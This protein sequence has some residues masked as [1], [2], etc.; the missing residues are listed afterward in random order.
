MRYLRTKLDQAKH[1]TQQI[2]QWLASAAVQN[3]YDLSKLEKMRLTVK[4]SQK[5][6]PS[7]T[8]TPATE[9]DVGEDE[10]KRTKLQE[11]N[12]KRNAKKKAKKKQE[13][14]GE[15]AG[16]EAP[17][18]PSAAESG[19]KPDAEQPTASP[20][21]SSSVS[22]QM[23]TEGVYFVKISQ[24]A[25][26]AMFISLKKVTIPVE[27][28]TLLR[29]SI[30]LRM[31]VIK[32]F[33]PAYEYQFREGDLFVNY[34]IALQVSGT[35]LHKR[36]ED[37]LQERRA[38]KGKGSEPA[39]S[40]PA[41]NPFENPDAI[42]K[43]LGTSIEDLPDIQL[44]PPERP[45]NAS[46]LPPPKVHFRLQDNADEM[47][48]GFLTFL[49]DL[50]DVR[51][52]LLQLWTDYGKGKIGLITA[53]MTTNVALDL[54]R[55]PH[56][57]ALAPL[58]DFY[59]NT[60]M[61]SAYAPVQYMIYK[62]ILMR[63]RPPD[64]PYQKSSVFPTMWIQ[65]PDDEC[66][67]LIFDN[68]FL[69]AWQI[70]D[71]L[72]PMIPAKGSA[73]PLSDPS[74]AFDV[75]VDLEK[76]S[77][78]ERWG[79]LE[80]L[81]R[82]NYCDYLLLVKDLDSEDKGDFE[83]DELAKSMHELVT[84]RQASLHT[85]FC[86]Q[87][88]V[89][90]NFQLRRRT[91]HSHLELKHTSQ[92]MRAVLQ[93]RRETERKPLPSTWGLVQQAQLRKLAE[94][95]DLYAEE[96]DLV[97]RL[98]REKVLVPEAAA[99]RRRNRKM[100]KM[101]EEGR[102]HAEV[103]KEEDDKDAD[104]EE[105]EKD[106]E[107]EGEKDE[108]KEEEIED[109]RK[110]KKKEEAEDK[111]KGPRLLMQ[112]N[113]VMAGS[114]LFRLWVQYQDVGLS[115]AN[116]WDSILA[117]A[118]LYHACRF[119]RGQDEVPAWPDMDLLF[120]LHGRGT[121]FGGEPPRTME[122]ARSCFVRM[123][124]S[125][126]SEQQIQFLQ[127]RKTS[128][129]SEELT[130]AKAKPKKKKGAGV[131]R[132]HTQIRNIFYRTGLDSTA[133]IEMSAIE[134]L[135]DDM[136][137]KEPSNVNDPPTRVPFRSDEHK[138]KSP[139]KYSP[140]QL[141][142]ILER[143]LLLEPPMLDYLSFHLTCLQLLKRVK[144]VL[145]DELV[146]RYGGV[147]YVGEDWQVGSVVG[148][149]LF[150]AGVGGEEMEQ[151]VGL[152]EGAR[153]GAVEEGAVE[154]G[155][156]KEEPTKE[157][158]TNVKP[159]K[160]EPAKEEPASAGI[161]KEE[162]AKEDCAKADIVKDQPA[163]EDSAS[164]DIAKEPGHSESSR[165]RTSE[166]DVSKKDISEEE[167]VSKEDTRTSEAGMTNL[168]TPHTDDSQQAGDGDSF[169]DEATCAAPSEDGDDPAARQLRADND[170]DP[171]SLGT[172]GEGAEPGR[173]ASRDE[174]A[175]LVSADGDGVSEAS[176]GIRDELVPGAAEGG[177]GGGGSVLGVTEGDADGSTMTTT[178]SNGDG[179]AVDGDGEKSEGKVLD[180]HTDELV[181]AVDDE[182]V[183]G[184]AND[185]GDQA[186]GTTSEQSGG[187][188]PGTTSG[189]D[190]E[191]EHVRDGLEGGGK[192]TT[193]SEAQI[194]ASAVNVTAGVGGEAVSELTKA[195]E[196]GLEPEVAVSHGDGEEFDAGGADAESASTAAEKEGTGDREG[197][198]V[199]D[200][201]SAPRRLLDLAASVLL[202]FLTESA[203]EARV[204]AD[205]FAE[206]KVAFG[207]PT[208]PE[209]DEVGVRK[210]DPGEEE[211]EVNTEE[212][213]ELASKDLVDSER[214]LESRDEGGAG[215][216]DDRDGTFD[217]DA[218]LDVEAE[219][220]E[221][222]REGKDAIM[223][224]DGLNLKAEAAVIREETD[225][226]EGVSDSGEVAEH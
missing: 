214:S 2:L 204:E 89:D 39:T 212:N 186:A 164:A 143:G 58:L 20:S 35:I 115:L 109:E 51:E 177:G 122:D 153:E 84:R 180:G 141:L 160:E 5:G 55:R 145:H 52:H 85:A 100:R 49:T 33:L 196:A 223:V 63:L 126:V 111:C 15:G 171:A 98:Y 125:D 209:K 112:R 175:R 94:T 219:G 197:S 176:K 224:Q 104:V 62:I 110:D 202:R 152:G 205:K 45:S 76:L 191:R 146:R 172:D 195:D 168:K 169:K 77:R 151:F 102:D 24:F 190:D 92:M 34:I 26:L 210:T 25:E 70:L 73:L 218:T 21:N 96:E 132:D 31:T 226:G 183:S 8:R 90:I 148:Y 116:S 48:M 37:A 12:A 147:E 136:A 74:K 86:A 38:R 124:K 201:P 56:D 6:L 1:D 61:H 188:V 161:V 170:D 95:L 11:K 225:D 40:T 130:K 173:D 42:L 28:L 18:S 59:K 137:G 119:I 43:E 46:S 139:T 87:I 29:R 208:M 140:R 44:P 193:A 27:L 198:E 156:A 41:P 47:Y 215:E 159:T 72:P 66:S 32:R 155:P 133:T 131:L 166:E 185:D 65:Q 106:E 158:P 189:D 53:A 16:E 138:H 113:P 108:K 57:E 117:A 200:G 206:A 121:L 99:E 178:S 120:D 103:G 80:Q 19:S 181:D 4:L 129:T 118:H 23:I 157:E 83:G 9:D 81:V 192:M 75:D 78:M 217:S 10:T 97:N 163:K 128:S 69:P 114:R 79:E 221:E 194:G 71:F 207:K 14:Q 203:E 174:P 54:L 82:K 68:M 36:R 179:A 60:P 123:V 17:D 165:N 3:G 50:H 213:T 142:S 22:Q 211:E 220:N 88:F 154:E 105:E 182:P 93:E 222:R 101:R 162:P 199:N 184:A 149:C 30:S 144:T 7:A 150:D 216:A 135:M 67:H 127:S 91:T 64:Q 107:R 187:P 134:K 167:A 13:K